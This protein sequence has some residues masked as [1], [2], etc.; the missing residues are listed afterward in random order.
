MHARDALRA[1]DI[2][3]RA[4]NN[5]VVAFLRSTDTH[6]ANQIAKRVCD[7]LERSRLR[8]GTL[9]ALALR[10]SATVVAGGRDGQSLVDFPFVSR[11][12]GRIP[13]CEADFIDEVLPDRHRIAT[14]PHGAFDPL[15]MRFARTGPRRARRRGVGGHHADRNCGICCAVG[16][17]FRRSCRI[18]HGFARTPPTAYR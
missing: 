18:C 1:G 8:T 4:S 17:H 11:G 2:L 16:G 3:F 13:R 6:T 7:T 9:S 5:D 10:F 14:D 15:T 12:R